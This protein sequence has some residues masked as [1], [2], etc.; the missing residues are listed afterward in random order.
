MNIYDYEMMK[1]SFN[2]GKFLLMQS[3]FCF[4]WIKWCFNG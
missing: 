1:M 4:F 3:F 2:V